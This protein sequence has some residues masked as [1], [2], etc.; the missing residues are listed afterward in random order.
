MVHLSSVLP[1]EAWGSYDLTVAQG[2]LGSLVQ[3]YARPILIEGRVPLQHQALEMQNKDIPREMM[4]APSQTKRSPRRSRPPR[5]L[6]RQATVLGSVTTEVE[7]K[8]FRQTGEGFAR[9]FLLQTEEE[10]EEQARRMARRLEAR[11]KS[12]S[13]PGTAAPSPDASPVRRGLQ[14]SFSMTTSSGWAWSPSRP[15]SRGSALGGGEHL[16]G[17]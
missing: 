6:T 9:S 16:W 13:R 15:V 11:S 4:E 7:V 14:Q 1:I 8:D 10:E 12:R 5:V 2:Q 3:R 17:L